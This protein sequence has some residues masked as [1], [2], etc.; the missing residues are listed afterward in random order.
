MSDAKGKVEQ[1]KGHLKQA[2]GELTDDDKLKSEGQ[3]DQVSGKVKEKVTC[4]RQS[5]RDD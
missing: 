5:R 3:T 1:A 4:R 2:A